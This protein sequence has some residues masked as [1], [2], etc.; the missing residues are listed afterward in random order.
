[1]RLA[2]FPREQVVRVEGYDAAGELVAADQIV[3]N[4]AR[5]GF[6]VMITEP[7]R[8]RKVTGT[9]MARAEVTVPEERRIES[10]ELRVNDELVTIL[11]SPPWQH[12]VEVPGGEDLSYLSVTALLDDGSR[13]EDVRF[14]KAPANLEEVEVNLIELF[15]T[16]TD[17]SGHPVR[18]LT[19]K[20]FEVLEAG[21]PQTLARFEQVENL[22][23]NLGIAID[24]SFSMAAALPEAHRAAAGFLR[25]VV[26]PKDRCFAVAFATRPAVLMPP[27]DDAEIV[28][29]S[30]EGMK[31]FGRTALYD[32]VITSLYYFRGQRGQRALVLLTDG[33]D[34]GSSTSW[35]DTL[36]YARRSGVAIY[37]IGLNM[38]DFKLGP[39][40]KLSELT[41]V[42]G[43]RAFFIG[44]AED[45][46]QVYGQIEDELRSRY[47]LAYNSGLPADENGFRK[48][49]VKARRGKARTG[50][51]YY[52]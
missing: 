24:T 37:A 4:Q 32:A 15:T 35:E 22:P 16:V 9:V 18:G 48:I 34:T 36:E 50:R 40:S 51:G 30:L 3:L 14:L 31:A 2:T 10:V 17:S 7:V 38:P 23:L 12:P 19:E 49:E 41:Q 43:G 52:P 5:G 47:F 45:L 42:S 29:L 39:R 28:A 25:E 33:E 13:A 6:R 44:Q 8:G 26:T 46:S 20:D 27:V 11:K 21:K 1:M